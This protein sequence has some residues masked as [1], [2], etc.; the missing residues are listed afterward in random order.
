MSKIKFGTDGWRAIIAKEFT[1]EN[2]IRVA[3]GTALWM[4]ARGQNSAVLGYDCR[5]GGEMF[6]T[7]TAR[8]LGAHGIK[9]YFPKGYTA[10]PVVSFGV[11][12]FKADVGVVITASHNPPLYN[13][14]KLKSSLGG[15]MF[16]ENV[17]EVEAL[18][19]EKAMTVLPTIEDLETKGLIEY[20]DLEGIYIEHIRSN[21]DLDL[22]NNARFN[23]AYDAMYGSGK[24]TMAKLLPNAALIHCEDNPGFNGIPPEPIHRNMLEFST[25]IK[26]NPHI[27]VGVANDGDADRLG[28]YDEDGNFVDAHHL[29]LLLLMYM[30]EFRKESG[31]V[32]VSFAVTDKMQHLAEKYGLEI[33]YTKIGF[34]HIC[35]YMVNEKVIVGGEEAGGFAV[36]GHIPERDGIWTAMVILEYMAKTGKSLKQLVAAIHAQVGSFAYDR[37]D[38]HIT[39]ELK[40]AIAYRC[41]EDP[42]THFGEYTVQEVLTI[43]GFKYMLDK[44]AWIMIR[45]SGT[46]PVLR[47]Y[48][49][50]ETPEKVRKLLDDA[51]VL[52]GV[53]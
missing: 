48:A 6:A 39:N 10:T 42:Y 7:T 19:P 49:Q 51:R 41:A 4:K 12:H 22:I 33:V 36:A 13:G 35:G 3:E 50:A 52:M 17:N 28:M 45:P 40:Q 20:P 18:I 5:F 15:P 43:D 32:V 8:V 1:V 21:F 25:F 44:G 37:D 34:K 31:K 23:I 53:D 24:G 9:V 11:V 16:S 26:N 47:V 29:L 2:V 30:H 46:E 27:H 14:Y 38:L